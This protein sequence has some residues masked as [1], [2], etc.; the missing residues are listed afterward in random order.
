[1]ASNWQLRVRESR[2]ENFAGA[3]SL[4]VRG[5]Q[6]R[7]K[8]AALSRRSGWSRMMTGGEERRELELPSRGSRII[9]GVRCLRNTT[10]Q[11]AATRLLWATNDPGTGWTGTGAN[12]AKLQGGEMATASVH[13]EAAVYCINAWLDC[14]SNNAG[15]QSCCSWQWRG[16]D[17]AGDGFAALAGEV[18]SGTRGVV[19]V[20]QV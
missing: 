8:P 10:A 12:S 6:V 7:K 14:C 3:A 13:E 11:S 2:N 15:R 20:L 1:M 19:A 9:F 5:P 18:R 16:G 4:V 17:D